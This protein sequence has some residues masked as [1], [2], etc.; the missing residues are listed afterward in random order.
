MG[1]IK[2]VRGDTK[3]IVFRLWE[4]KDNGTALDISGFTFKFTVNKKKAPI[5]GTDDPEFTLVGEIVLPASDGRVRFLPSSID[6]NLPPIS[7][8]PVIEYFYDFEVTD[9]EGFIGTED[10]G[11]FKLTQDITK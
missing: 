3:P 7:T 1:E 11:K 6:S 10:L 9:A 8:S 4:N 5:E 2:Y